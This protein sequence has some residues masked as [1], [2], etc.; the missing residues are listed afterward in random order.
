MRCVGVAPEWFDALLR[1]DEVTS[2]VGFVMATTEAGASL[3]SRCKF[4]QFSRVSNTVS[5]IFGG[6]EYRSCVAQGSWKERRAARQ[7]V[8]AQR[9]AARMSYDNEHPLLGTVEDEGLGH[10]R[11]GSRRTCER[12][13]ETGIL[14][15]ARYSPISMNTASGSPLSVPQSRPATGF[16]CRGTMGE[17]AGDGSPTSQRSRPITHGGIHVRAEACRPT[18]V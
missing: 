1:R 5:P 6:G 8:A 18:Y 10:E 3:R 2:H 14:C 13:T 7:R 11:F 15:G 17:R 12:D 16:M 4:I 9:R